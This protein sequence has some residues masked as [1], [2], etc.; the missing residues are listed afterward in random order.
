MVCQYFEKFY[1][2]VG[3]WCCIV[4]I[5][6]VNIVEFDMFLGDY[7]EFEFKF[8]EVLVMFKSWVGGHFGLGVFYDVMG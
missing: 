6:W 2:N 7:K 5:V 1:E 3:S 8:F 4:V